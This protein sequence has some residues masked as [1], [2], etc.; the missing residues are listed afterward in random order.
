[1]NDE[2]EQRESREREQ[3]ESRESRERQRE[4]GREAGREGGR[5][6]Y[7]GE[8]VLDT[9]DHARVPL[10]DSPEA[11]EVAVFLALVSELVS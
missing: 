2:R 5:E 11:P 9:R 1:M 7:W 6:I 8:E 10:Q 4:T 3:R